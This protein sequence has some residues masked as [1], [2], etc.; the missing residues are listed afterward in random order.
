MIIDRLGAKP[1]V[2]QLPIGIESDFVGVV[3][4]VRMKSVVWKDESLGAE[5]TVGEIPADMKEKAE[6][7]RHSL[8]ESVVEFDEAVLEAYL[9]G[10]EPD[11]A[12]IKRL[13]RK[14][15]ITSTIVPVICG[16]A[17]K[18]KG[19]QLLLDAVID[20][21]PSPTDVPDVVGVKPD[22]DE[23]VTRKSSDDEPFSGLAFKIMTDPF[24]GSLT[25]VRIY[26]GV[27][28]AGQQVLN[29]VKGDKER[30]GRMLQMHANHR[31]DIKEAR[32]GDIVALAGLKGTTTGDTLCDPANPV[33][34]ERMEFPE[35]VIEVAVEPK[36]K[37]DQEKMG[38]ALNRLAQEDPSFRV[39]SD[40]E[41]GQTIIK[42]MGELHL[43][44]IVDRM[45]REFKVE[46]NVGAPQVAY[47]ETISR[48][49]EQDY[50]HKKQTGGSGQFARVKI[51]FEP[52]PPGGGFEFENDVVGGSVP[53]EYVPGVEKGLKAA[54][55]SGVIAGFPLIDF[56]ATL[57]DGAY[58]DVDSNVLT[59]DIAARACYREGI[60]KAGPK[61]LEP[62][63]KVEVVTPDEYMGDVIGDLNSRRGQVQG[64]DSRG[65]ARVIDAM[66]PLANMFGYVNTLRSMSQGRAQ[67]TMHFDHYEQVPQAVADEVRAKMA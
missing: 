61:L 63:M 50:T 7:Y 62:I 40:A 21:L 11:E 43:E 39:S 44:I 28:A 29:T 31:E 25:F 38:L 46:A 3:D 52:L 53:R 60:P 34:L 59:F 49:V 35:P 30:C 58:H 48:K 12:T 41:S 67:Y 17:F 2:L 6:K 18:N 4:L 36:T 8:I 24:V 1:L 33:I 9:D 47:R 19:V 55:E 32:A 26:S 42:G 20:F 13:I 37:G 56:K 27:L 14:G 57:I 51:R 22:S 64:L 15:T 65:N 16:S 10:K 5:F 23:P 54:K 66:V 45:K